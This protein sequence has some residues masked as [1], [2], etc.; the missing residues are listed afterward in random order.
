[1]NRKMVNYDGVIIGDKKFNSYVCDSFH[2]T[3][4]VQRRNE[5]RTENIVL[6]NQKKVNL[7]R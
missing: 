5:K 3:L 1:M 7:L 2:S 6:S 4:Q